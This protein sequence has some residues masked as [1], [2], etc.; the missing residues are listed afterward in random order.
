MHANVITNMTIEVTVNMIFRYMPMKPI[1][2]KC[3]LF[4]N[5]ERRGAQ[6]RKTEVGGIRYPLL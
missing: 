3:S 2:P 5:H 4:R 1:Q 6:F